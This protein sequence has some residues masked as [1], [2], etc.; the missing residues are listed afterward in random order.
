LW[1]HRQQTETYRGVT[2]S[3]VWSLCVSLEYLRQA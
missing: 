3:A 2:A 1:Q